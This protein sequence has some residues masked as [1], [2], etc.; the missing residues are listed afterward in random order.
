MTI[1][2]C[3]FDTL[4]QRLF[5]TGTSVNPASNTEQTSMI[6]GNISPDGCVGTNC[7]DTLYIGNFP[8]NT[9]ASGTTVAGL[10]IMPNPSTGFLHIAPR[11]AETF[12]TN[13]IEIRNV[14][15]QVVFYTSG[16]NITS[17]DVSHLPNNVYIIRAT[18]EN[19]QVIVA[20]FIKT[21]G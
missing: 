8:S 7:N 10:K 20:T 17:L 15:G 9:S 19:G 18:G 5:F 16:Y 21:G 12:V 1:N 11:H 6:L 4:Q 3:V 13:Q 2:S 14:Q